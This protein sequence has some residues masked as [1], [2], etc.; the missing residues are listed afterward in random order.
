MRA[1]ACVRACVPHTS[2]VIN[3]SVDVWYP[4]NTST[5]RKYTAVVVFLISDHAVGKDINIRT[6][7]IQDTAIEVGTI[8]MVF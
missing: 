6:K 1:R 7:I 5:T 3:Q 8:S 4:R 2:V